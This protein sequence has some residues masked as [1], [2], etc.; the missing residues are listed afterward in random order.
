[1][2]CEEQ[3]DQVRELLYNRKFEEVISKSS[4]L[5]IQFPTMGEQILALCAQAKNSLGDTEGTI[6]IQV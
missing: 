4:N 5:L 3:I 1:M 2:N 6:R